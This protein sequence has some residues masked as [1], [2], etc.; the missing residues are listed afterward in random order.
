MNDID[1]TGEMSIYISTA[2]TL[3]C[4]TGLPESYEVIQ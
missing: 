4:Y 3:G 1:I 2:K